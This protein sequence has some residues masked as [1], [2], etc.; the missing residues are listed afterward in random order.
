MR[1]RQG[2]KVR[3]GGEGERGRA[4]H[5]ERGSEGEGREVKHR[6]MEDRETNQQGGKTSSVSSPTALPTHHQNRASD[7]LPNIHL[8]WP[9]DYVSDCIIMHLIMH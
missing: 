9:A 8:L 5:R 1:E 7:P 2:Q 4:P 3:G 6:S